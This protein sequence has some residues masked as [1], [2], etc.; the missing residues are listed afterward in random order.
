MLGKVNHWSIRHVPRSTN[1]VAHVLAENVL[2][3]YDEI[4]QLED[5]CPFEKSSY[6]N[7]EIAIEKKKGVFV[8]I[9]RYFILDN[10]ISLCMKIINSVIMV[11][12]YYRFLTTF[13]TGPSY[14]FLLRANPKK[15]ID[16]SF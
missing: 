6:K 3:L 15:Y 8:M 4:I 2:Y 9:F 11:E 7:P 13:F 12:L 10:L 16:L 1:N 5:I 14:L